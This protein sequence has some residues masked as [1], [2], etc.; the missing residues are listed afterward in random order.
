MGGSLINQNPGGSRTRMKNL[1]TIDGQPI[2]EEDRVAALVDAHFLWDMY[3]PNSDEGTNP[4]GYSVEYLREKVHH[5]L[6]RT[7]S[8]SAPR[9]D[10]IS[11]KVL[12]LANKMVLGDK[13]METVAIELARGTIPRE[14]QESKVVF[15]PKPG[16]DN[17]QLKGWRP[18]TLINCIGKLGE[19]VVGN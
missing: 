15:I 12:K 19:K 14:W 6:S 7:S 16:K 18:I 5:A 10:G 1:T 4:T 8:S 3:K 13:I 9:P 17:I 11:Y 2:S